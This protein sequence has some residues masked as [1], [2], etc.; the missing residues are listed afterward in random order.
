MYLEQFGETAA[1]V[2][3]HHVVS[4]PELQSMMTKI[5]ETL[6][7][8]RNA[9]KRNCVLYARDLWHTACLLVFLTLAYFFLRQGWLA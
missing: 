9:I 1:I 7:E 5:E 6:Q 8:K 3:C 4:L 2:S